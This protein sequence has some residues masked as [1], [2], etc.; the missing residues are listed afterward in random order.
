MNPLICEDAEKRMVEYLAQA[1][2]QTSWESTILLYAPSLDP[3]L[4][5]MAGL[6]DR[7]RLFCIYGEPRL[8]PK[9]GR[10]RRGC[11]RMP[12]ER[13]EAY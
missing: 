10:P 4:Q 2:K 12:R 9:A 6:A 3:H 11:R 8:R 1:L 5:K 7:D 13:L